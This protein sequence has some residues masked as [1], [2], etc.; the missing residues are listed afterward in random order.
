MLN[1]LRQVAVCESVR[2]MIKQA[3]AQSDDAGIRQ[4]ANAIPTHDSILRAVSLDPSINDEET[5]KA[6]IVKHILTNLRLT[7]TQKEYLNLNG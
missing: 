7:E 2:E 1:Y 3:L 4:K 6:F 5:L